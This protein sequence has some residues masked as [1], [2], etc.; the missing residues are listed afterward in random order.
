[1]F[2]LAK[3]VEEQ[4]NFFGDVLDK[5]PSQVY[6]PNPLVLVIDD[7][8]PLSGKI[9]AL[10]KSELVA[11]VCWSLSN[12]PKLVKSGAPSSEIVNKVPHFLCARSSRVELAAVNA[13]IELL[14]YSPSQYTKVFW[15]PVLDRIKTVPAIEYGIC[16]DE[17]CKSVPAATLNNELLPVIEQLFKQS[18]VF[19]RLAS[20]VLSVL[21]AEKLNLTVQQFGVFVNSAV[22]VNEFLV[23]VSS[24]F[25]KK[26]G[27]EWLYKDLP[28]E[29]LKVKKDTNR[30]GIAS[31]FIVNM[32]RI[33]LQNVYSELLGVYEW[34]T[35]DPEIA[36]VWLNHADIVLE[37]R[38]IDFLAKTYQLINVVCCSEKA[39]VRRQ[40]PGILC[41]KS[42]LLNKAPEAIMKGAFE[43]LAKDKDAKV[44]CVFLEKIAEIHEKVED[45][46][47]A[48]SLLHIFFALLKEK[49]KHLLES[50][51]NKHMLIAISQAS[52]PGIMQ[53]VMDLMDAVK[54]KWRQ[55]TSL[56]AI[57]EGFPEKIVS[58]SLKKM[59]IMVENGVS[60]NPQALS[61]SAIS[62]YAYIIHSKFTTIRLTELM[63]Y[64]TVT[65]A[66]SEKFQ[67]RILYL[68][69]AAALLNELEP[70]FYFENVFSVVAQFKNEQ[71]MFVRAALVDYLTTF[72]K[73]YNKDKP[74]FGQQ[75]EALMKN[76][77]SDKD[78]LVVSKLK[79]AR[80]AIGVIPIKKARSDSL[81]RLSH[82]PSL[83]PGSGHAGARIKTAQ[84]PRRP[85]PTAVNH[86]RSNSAFNQHYMEH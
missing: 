50:L 71:V 26:F 30:L 63:K 10:M 5:R 45:T 85:P 74:R 42:V 27:T 79:D 78:P 6:K 12:V 59:M 77:E 15:T 62:F 69:I 20:F 76:I 66:E 35:S 70:E 39:D 36:I 3:Y 86:S 56:L 81:S 18:E 75:L 48:T 33:K 31:F 58:A 24:S 7:K 4:S 23:K 46:K 22:F 68:K 57:I 17:M 25:S 29:L 32:E 54:D 2:V 13:A 40:L 41:E 60:I 44:Q 37:S 43:K 11:Q 51:I 83:L 19:Q 65:F 55:F 64:L 73:H 8:L 61:R 80:D 67:L 82:R 21:P 72:V 14:K 52:M 49:P 16:I 38:F 84:I 53:Y 47:L 34:A 9:E 28:E 1:M